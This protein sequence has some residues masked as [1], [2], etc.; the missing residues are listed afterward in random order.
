MTI[1][2]RA[3]DAA[4]G[5]YVAARSGS[6]ELGSLL[7]RVSAADGEGHAALPLALGAAAQL[8]AL[9]STGD[10]PWIGDGSAVSFAVARDDRLYL[11]RNWQHERTIAAAVRSRLNDRPL[12]PADIEA[13]LAKISGPLSAEQSAAIAAAPG[14]GL[15]LLTGGPGTGKTTTARALVLLLLELAHSLGWPTEP[16]IMLAAP[17]GKAAQRLSAAIGRP[18]LTVHSLLKYRP[19]TA[20]FEHNRQEPLAADLVLVDEAS[21]LDLPLMRGLLEA[22]PAAA[23]LVLLGDPDQLQSVAAG[24]VLA[25]LVAALAPGGAVQRLHT[26][27]RNDVA[28][29]PLIEAVRNGATEL[30]PAPLVYRGPAQT[31]R[32]GLLSWAHQ[33]RWHERGRW[34]PEQALASLGDAQILC[35]LRAGPGGSDA[36]SAAIDQHLRAHEGAFDLWYPGR[37]V[38]FTRNDPASGLANGDLGIAIEIE[39]A[40]RLVTAGAAPGQ[41]A[42]A[43]PVLRNLAELPE[44]VPAFALTVHKSQGSEYRRIALVL[45]PTADHPLLTRQLLYTALTRAREAIDVWGDE[46]GL[47]AAAA[48]PAVRVGGLREQLIGGQMP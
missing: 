26:G 24:T 38:M 13:A 43:A 35:A 11:W 19:D 15:F 47:L 42:P 12:P 23:S 34:P 4:F 33:Q 46:S 40:L 8:R 17:T 31:P 18:A 27:F 28:L 10:P 30:P 29:L 2:L 6:E 16:R 9:Y 39:G 25:D 20:G 48:R 45:P 14:R 41:F 22:L 21:M 1:N 7:A 36:L 44:H 3:F 37:V 5:D 32:E